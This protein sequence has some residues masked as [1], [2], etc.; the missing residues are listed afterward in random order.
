MSSPD[1]CQIAPHS[2]KFTSVEELWSSQKK[3]ASLT[4]VGAFTT[5]EC[6]PWYGFHG[7]PLH[8]EE[9]LVGKGT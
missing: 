2:G 6:E 5:Q 4:M 3:I 7:H 1:L 9:E 8:A